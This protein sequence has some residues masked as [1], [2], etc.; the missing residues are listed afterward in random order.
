MNADFT[1]SVIIPT[2]NA[3]ATLPACLASLRPGAALI[4]DIILVDGGST[5]GTTKLAPGARILHAPASRGGQLRA[6]IAASSGGFL[7]LLHADTV[8]SPNWPEAA[9]AAMQTPGI[10]HYFRFRLDSPAVPARILEAIVA[11]RCRLLRLPYGD[12]GLL[13]SRARLA[14]AGG[15][16]DLPLMEDVALARRLRKTLR[17]LAATALTSAARYQRDGWLRRPLRNLVCMTLY[18]AGIP[19]ARIKKLYG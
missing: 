7:L 15:I 13:I 14:A 3:A 17:P 10:A 11:L 8:L 2:L 5:D 12:Q 4:H 19:P 16:P 18:F 1:L 9:A 6:G